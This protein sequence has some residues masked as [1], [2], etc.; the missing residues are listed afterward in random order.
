MDRYRGKVYNISFALITEIVLELFL[1]SSSGSLVGLVREIKQM[2]EVLKHSEA[3]ITKTANESAH[4]RVTGSM[5]TNLYYNIYYNFLSFC[6]SQ[7]CSTYTSLG[8][9]TT[10]LHIYHPPSSFSTMSPSE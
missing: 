8:R 4:V 9:K 7:S 2:N 6:R 1:P 3:H 10:F 5:V